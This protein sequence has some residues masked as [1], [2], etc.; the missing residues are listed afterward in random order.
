MQLARGVLAR[1]N[2]EEACVGRDD[3]LRRLSLLGAWG[4]G[5]LLAVVDDEDCEGLQQPDL[6]RQLLQLLA[7]DEDGL[8]RAC[9]CPTWGAS[10]FSGQPM[11]TR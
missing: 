4:E 7:A 9:S 6:G 1:L 11:R 8:V 5:Q 10:S 2:D 3:G